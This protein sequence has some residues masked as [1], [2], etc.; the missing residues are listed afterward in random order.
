MRG[1]YVTGGAAA[2]ITSRAAG[3]VIDGGGGDEAVKSFSKGECRVRV[4][5]VDHDMW[6]E[7]TVNGQW[8]GD[9]ARGRDV[10]GASTGCRLATSCAGD[11]DCGGYAWSNHE[12]KPSNHTGR[13]SAEGEGCGSNGPYPVALLNRRAGEG[14]RLLVW[15]QGPGGWVHQEVKDVEDLKLAVTDLWGAAGDD[16][17][18]LRGGRVLEGRT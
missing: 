16:W 4:E 6:G 17:W 14:Q 8:E 13:Y 7:R 10:S 11:G 15:L 9:G 18:L 3:I 2:F 5:P 1:L 12:G